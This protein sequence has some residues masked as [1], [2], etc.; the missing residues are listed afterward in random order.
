MPTAWIIVLSLLAIGNQWQNTM[1]E[2][3]A[4][5]DYWENRQF[6]QDQIYQMQQMN[7]NLQ[8]RGYR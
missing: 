3:R 8:N 1:A 4:I 6:Q 7:W 2:Q 5:S